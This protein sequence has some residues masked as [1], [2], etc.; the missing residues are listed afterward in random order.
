MKVYVVIESMWNGSSYSVDAD[1]DVY[2]Y[3]KKEDAETH[4]NVSTQMY[5]GD[6]I[7]TMEEK[8]IITKYEL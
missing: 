2:I 1:E 6:A 5:G 3:E 7:V 8:E 4:L